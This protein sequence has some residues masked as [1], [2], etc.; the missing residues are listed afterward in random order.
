M[1]VVLDTNVIVSSYLSRSSPPTRIRAHIRQGTIRPVVSRELL[2]EYNR[3]LNY[4]RVSQLHG[5]TPEQ[6]AA[7]L[8]DLRQFAE[9][10]LLD[11]IVQV[12]REDPTDDIVLA[13]ALCGAAA[14]IVTGDGHLLSRRQYEGIDIVSP[15][16][17]L[18]TLEEFPF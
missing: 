15:A 14:Y 1:R 10:V 12:I 13:T 17:F 7:E 16:A 5:M 18:L 3:A 6:V 11:E 9:S 4:P 2:D 8:G